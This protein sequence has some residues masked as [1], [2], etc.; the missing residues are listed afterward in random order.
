MT[1]ENPAAL[2]RRAA[3]KARSLAAAAETSV[4]SLQGLP[5]HTDKHFETRSDLRVL[6]GGAEPA[7]YVQPVRLIADAATPELASF[8]AAMHLGVGTAMAILLDAEAKRVEMAAH[9]DQAET[10]APHVFT[11]A[12]QL[13]GE[14]PK[15][16]SFKARTRRTRE[17]RTP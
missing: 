17:P 7:D 15:S 5:W 14:M 8:I 2:L 9:P 3:E 4:N 12:R 6:Q 11:L 10:I 1:V 16:G 13:L